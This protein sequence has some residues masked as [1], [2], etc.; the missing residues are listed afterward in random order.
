MPS[1]HLPYFTYMSLIHPQKSGKGDQLTKQLHK[2]ATYS[3][4]RWV[5]IREQLR[6]INEDLGAVMEIKKNSGV[7]QSF[8]L[9]IDI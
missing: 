3:C 9:K 6:E 2:V 5:L 8:P 1:Q 4:S 7:L